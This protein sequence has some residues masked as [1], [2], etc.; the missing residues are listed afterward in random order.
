MLIRVQ[1]LLLPPDERPSEMFGKTHLNV[2]EKGSACSSFRLQQ[3]FSFF[4]ERALLKSFFVGEF[5][6]TWQSHSAWGFFEKSIRKKFQPLPIAEKWSDFH[7]VW[8]G[9][10]VF[11]LRRID[12]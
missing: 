9:W 7:P 5:G 11:F 6:L 2:E 4:I 3:I 10:L 12:F 8:T 1:N